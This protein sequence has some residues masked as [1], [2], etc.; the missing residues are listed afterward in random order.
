MP[1]FFFDQNKQKLGNKK[2]FFGQLKN[3]IEPDINFLMRLK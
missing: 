2:W 1:F 3:Q